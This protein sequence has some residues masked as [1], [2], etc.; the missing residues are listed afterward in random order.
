MGFNVLLHGTQ[1]D[2]RTPRAVE[3]ALRG[4]KGA[5]TLDLAVEFA[6][7]VHAGALGFERRTLAVSCHITAAGLRKDVHISSQTCKSRFG[8]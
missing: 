4:S 7:Q 3:K 5:V 8:N 2:G 6:V 1:R